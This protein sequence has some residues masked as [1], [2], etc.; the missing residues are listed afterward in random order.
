MKFRKLNS[1][2]GPFTVEEEFPCTS[3]I[4]IADLSVN[5]LLSWNESPEGEN[6]RETGVRLFYSW[7]R[8]VVIPLSRAKK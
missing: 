7:S 1:Q 5:L 2:H 6:L 8:V 4:W 3:E